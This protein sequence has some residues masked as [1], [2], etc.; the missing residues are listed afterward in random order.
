VQSWPGFATPAGTFEAL[1]EFQ[2]VSDGVAN[3]VTLGFVG[4]AGFFCPPLAYQNGGQK[5]VARPTGLCQKLAGVC[6]PGQSV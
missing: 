3:P 1:N 2:N 6:D 4:R 5:S